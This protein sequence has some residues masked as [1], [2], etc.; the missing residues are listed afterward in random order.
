MPLRGLRRAHAVGHARP[1]LS[2]DDGRGRSPEAAYPSGPFNPVES[3]RS[4]RL[5]AGRRRVSYL[6]RAVRR[7]SDLRAR[8]GAPASGAGLPRLSAGRPVRR[9]PSVAVYFALGRCIRTASRRY[10]PSTRGAFTYEP[11]PPVSNR[12]RPPRAL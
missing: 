11:S 2:S 8:G 10:A 12:V 6:P 5:A 7:A 4:E 3:R 9:P 1:G